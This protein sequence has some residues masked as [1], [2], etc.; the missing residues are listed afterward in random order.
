MVNRVDRSLF[1]FFGID[2]FYHIVA[3]ARHD[4]HLL[5]VG[6][7][8]GLYLD[9]Q[10]G[11]LNEIAFETFAT[12][13]LNRV[14]KEITPLTLVFVLGQAGPSCKLRR[15]TLV[16]F[17]RLTEGLPVLDQSFEYPLGDF[18]R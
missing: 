15:V 7:I 3:F 14:H 1:H 11:G 13:S 12:N 8:T 18:G 17:P 6:S 9:R 5:G 2:D 10:H 16:A 4:T